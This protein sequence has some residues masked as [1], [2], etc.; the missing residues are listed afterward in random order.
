MLNV[1]KF[2]GLLGPIFPKI[3][4][5]IWFNIVHTG[6]RECSIPH[7]SSRSLFLVIQASTETSHKVDFNFRV[8]VVI[9]KGSTILFLDA[10]P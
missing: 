4:L 8:S 10:P 5:Q 3:F 7:M 1:P 2:R 6:Y 9:S